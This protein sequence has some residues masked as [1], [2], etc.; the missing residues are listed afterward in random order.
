MPG[1]IIRVP[2][3]QG[4]AVKAGDVIV[5]L[6]AMKMENEICAPIDGT[7]KELWVKRGDIV[8]QNKKLALIE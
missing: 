2:V 3:Q 1:L 7:V 5:V 4:D 6:E 8:E